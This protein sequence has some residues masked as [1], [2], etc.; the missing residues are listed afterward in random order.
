MELAVSDIAWT[1][2]QDS[3]A[4]GRLA[5]LGVNLLEMA[6]TRVVDRLDTVTENDRESL[7][8]SARSCGLKVTGFQALLFG[9]PELTLFESEKARTACATYLC[10]VCDLLSA[11]GGRS[12][13][14]G[15]PKNR[16]RGDMPK[17][18]ADAIAIPFFREIGKHALQRGVVL[19]LEPNP[20]AYACDYLVTMDEVIDVVRRVDSPGVRLQVD[21]G[22]LTMNEEDA[23]RVIQAC[24]DIIGHVHISEPML[25]DFTTPTGDHAA[26]GRA[27]RD[28]GYEGTISI[29]MR[30]QPSGWAAVEQAVL[31]ARQ[32]YVKD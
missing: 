12:L 23:E 30:A 9:Q 25:G 31:F 3:E 22:E 18:Q 16:Q 7:L 5:R 8:N 19:C 13:V 26:Y 1:P 21:G 11:M 15:S 32:H 28:I 10:K 17:E 2:D 29:E 20:S 14:F 24:Q 6:P 4:H 27:L